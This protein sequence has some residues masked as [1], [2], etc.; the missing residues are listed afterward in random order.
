M[1]ELIVITILKVLIFL[2]NKW[3]VMRL[4]ENTCLLS[5]DAMAQLMFIFQKR[6]RYLATEVM[7]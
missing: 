5:V 3:N 1:Y 6:K 4:C 7:Q 2:K